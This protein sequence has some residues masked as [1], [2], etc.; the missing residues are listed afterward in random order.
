MTDPQTGS[1]LKAASMSPGKKQEPE[2]EESLGTGQRAGKGRGSREG[3]QAPPEN[4]S[5]LSTWE[6]LQGELGG[7]LCIAG[8][9]GSVCCKVLSEG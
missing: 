1:S 9:I 4:Y 7:C 8:S 2:Q 3:R 6:G 5:Y